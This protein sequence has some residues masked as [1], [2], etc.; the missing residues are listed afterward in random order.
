MEELEHLKDQ[1]EK[2][3]SKRGFLY[4]IERK[5][6]QSI[7]KLIEIEEIKMNARSNRKRKEDLNVSQ[8]YL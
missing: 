6:L 8:R 5:R 1:V 4:P 2:V 7:N 3:E